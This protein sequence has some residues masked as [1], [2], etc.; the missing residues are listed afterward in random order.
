MAAIGD[1]VRHGLFR[2]SQEVES[3]DICAFILPFRLSSSGLLC[4]SNES[5]HSRLFA[6]DGL[7]QRR[8]RLDVLLL[9]RVH[10]RTRSDPKISLVEETVGSDP[11]R[12]TSNLFGLR[13]GLF[14]FAKRISRFVVQFRCSANARLYC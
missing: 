5:V 7:Q 14:A 3:R 8:S 12:T 4:V 2:S 13:N 10:L 6:P 1:L 9:R 11:I